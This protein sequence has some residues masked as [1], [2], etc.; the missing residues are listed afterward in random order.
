ML[1]LG[2]PLVEMVPMV[3]ANAANFHKPDCLVQAAEQR[4]A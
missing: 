4:V 1:A 3:R 2:L